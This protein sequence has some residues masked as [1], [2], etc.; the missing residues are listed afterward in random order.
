MKTSTFG[1]AAL[2]AASAAT[3]AMIAAPA[4]A[5][6]SFKPYVELGFGTG[7]IDASDASGNG[8]T[9]SES[10]EYSGGFS[11]G[12][13]DLIGPFDLRLDSYSS[14]I[15]D[16]AITAYQAEVEVSST[17]LN[18]LYTHE[19]SDRLEI[20]GGGGAGVAEVYYD[21]CSFCFPTVLVEGVD[22]KFSWQ[23]VGGVRFKV[24]GGF[25]VFVEGR[26]MGADGFEINETPSTPPDP[27]LTVNYPTDYREFTAIGGIRWQF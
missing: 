22:E 27:L 24:I 6:V 20:Y 25:G 12:L 11:L 26:Y 21:G 16:P 10:T 1:F 2:L 23:A 9:I 13:A 8:A 19:L 7:K 4:A 17:Y 3:S 18:V 5:Q 15:Q 14:Q